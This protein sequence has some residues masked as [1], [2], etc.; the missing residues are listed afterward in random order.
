MLKGLQKKWKVGGVKLLFILTAFALGGTLTGYL[1]RKILVLAGISN[2]LLS[3]PLY[4]I[5][6]TLL[7][8]FSVLLVSYP[9]GQY[10]F[11]LSYVKKIGMKL[12]WKNREPKEGTQE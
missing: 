3:I 7:W 12:G 9:L 10:A 1:G 11:F 6:V 2:P 5:V 8:P 4:I